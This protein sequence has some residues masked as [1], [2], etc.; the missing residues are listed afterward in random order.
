MV[1][2]VKPQNDRLIAAK[3]PA[4]VLL[5]LKRKLLRESVD[6]SVSHALRALITMYVND[7]IVLPGEL[8][9]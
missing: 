8:T 2:K 7:K 6:Y 3:L 5:K 4:V 9:K 1:E